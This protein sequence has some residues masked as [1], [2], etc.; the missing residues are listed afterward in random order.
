MARSH[1]RKIAIIVASLVVLVIAS[2]TSAMLGVTEVNLAQVLHYITGWWPLGTYEPMTNQQWVAFA[3]IRLPRI[4]VGLCAGVALA[5]AGAMMQVITGNA[6]ASPFTTGISNAAAFGASLAVLSGFSIMHSFELGIIILAFCAAGLCSLLVFGIAS[7]HG[8]GKHTIVLT[9]IA[10]SYLF[11]ALSA[12]MQFIADERELSQIVTW[13]FGNLGKANW[14]QIAILAAITAA[15]VGIGIAY[16]RAY[17]LISSGEDGA[18]AMGINVT[19]VRRITSIAVTLLAATA[20]S[21]VG[22]IGFVGLVAPHL[23]RLL[24]GFNYRYSFAL[25]LVMGALLVVCADL[26]GR[27]IISPSIIP[28]GIVVSIIG[29]PFFLWLIISRSH[30]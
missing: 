4:G 20:V 8:M 17:T 13:T 23:A 5:A 1:F 25:T 29:M 11:S 22:V 9:G 24:V 26:V 30:A 18:I 14:H 10:F 3:L 28:V 2:I 15:G 7:V 12:G 6:M 21:F 19:Q 27:T 16:S